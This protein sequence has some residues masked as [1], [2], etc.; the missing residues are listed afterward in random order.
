MS[1]KNYMIASWAALAVPAI[2][3]DMEKRSETSASTDQ[4]IRLMLSAGFSGLPKSFDVW[5]HLLPYASDIEAALAEH[6]LHR[7]GD[8]WKF[9]AP[10]AKGKPAPK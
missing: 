7:R 4:V 8:Q 2:K 10:A 9:A 3:E 1:A 6:N 5:T